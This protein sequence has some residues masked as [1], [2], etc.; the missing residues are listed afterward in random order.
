MSEYILITENLSKSFPGADGELT[1]LQA[2]DIK[3]EQGST[4]AIV[5]PSGSGK[6]T[7]GRAS[8]RLVKPVRGSIIFNGQDIT[9]LD[10]GGLKP[11]RRKAQVVFQD[12]QVQVHLGQFTDVQMPLEVETL[13][14]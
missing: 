12:R 11:F 8:V 13:L 1:I 7:L 10:E 4:C 3:V 9:G 2:I 14:S 6:T 5:G